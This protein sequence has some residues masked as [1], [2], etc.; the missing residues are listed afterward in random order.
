MSG[1]IGFLLFVLLISIPMIFCLVLLC[2]KTTYYVVYKRVGFCVETR[3]CYI[4]AKGLA[5]V[6]CQLEAKHDP[7]AVIILSIKEVG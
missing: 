2:S 4:K 5:D 7:W 3:A 6:Q 1:W